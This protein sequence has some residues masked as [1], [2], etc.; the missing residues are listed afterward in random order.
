MSR[1]R[2][3]LLVLASILLAA[4]ACGK[5]GRPVRSRA[6]HTTSP[7]AAEAQAVQPEEHGAAAEEAQE[8]K[9][10]GQ[11]SDEQGTVR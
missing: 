2:G 7:S 3:A 1:A 6:V 8:A 9:E 11:G 5:Y 10:E 4:T